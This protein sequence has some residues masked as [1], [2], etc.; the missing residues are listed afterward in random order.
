MMDVLE[1]RAVIATDKMKYT[2]SLEIEFYERTLIELEKK[3]KNK[4]ET[5]SIWM[6]VAARKD[7]YRQLYHVG[8]ESTIDIN[9]KQKALLIKLFNMFKGYGWTKKHGWIGFPKTAIIPELRAL[10]GEVC[11]YEGITSFKWGIGKTATQNTLGVDFQGIGCDGLIPTTF[12]DLETCKFLHLNWNLIKGSLPSS[13]SRLD[14]IEILNLS[15]NL[16]Q[17]NLDINSFSSFLK[18]QKLD[19]SFNQ[20]I[21][22]IP[23]CFDKMKHLKFLNLSDNNFHGELPDS[24]SCLKDLEVLKCY[25]NNL[26]GH[27]P[28][29]IST[30]NLRDV[31][32][33]QNQ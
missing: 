23:D 18:I 21:G 5:A 15:S 25:Q 28:D 14:N 33:S 26:H 20:F 8:F 16:L 19:L 4:E 31:N 9:R 24:M 30:L 29:W 32:L 27:I 11:Y 22:Y 1:E 7:L 2:M 3:G 10:E 13:L 17:G 6:E 12:G